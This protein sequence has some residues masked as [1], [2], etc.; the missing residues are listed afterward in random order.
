MSVGNGGFFGGW[1]GSREAAQTPL[2]AR[3]APTFGQ[4]SGGNQG[5]NNGGQQQR[6]NQDNNGGGGNNNDDHIDPIEDIWNDPKIEPG[7]Q[8]QNTQQP[9]EEEH[10]T[11]FDNYIGKLD[12]KLPAFSPEQQTRLANG[13]FGPIGEMMDKGMKAA[14]KQ[15]MIDANKVVGKAAEKAADAAFNRST[16]SV[17]ADQFV[18][19]MQTKLEFTKDP[20]ISPIAKS[21][22]SRFIG[23]GQ[24]VDTAIDNTAKYF[25]QLSSKASEGMGTNQRNNGR[26][27]SQGY[28]GG[29]TKE[30]EPDW[31]AFMVGDAGDQQ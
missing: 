4:N 19:R 17:K 24:D 29:R 27:G 31:L 9:T 5:G 13:D 18:D 15:A 6:N 25:A 7:Q 28:N 3:E 11:A 23:K 22:L 2:A 8:Q 16:T 12:F 21:V 20:S 10:Q 1:R 14:Y 30:A 26:P